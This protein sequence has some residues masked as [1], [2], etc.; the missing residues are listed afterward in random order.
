MLQWRFVRDFNGVLLLI[1]IF[2]EPEFRNLCLQDFLAMCYKYMISQ[3]AY[4]KSI[5]HAAKHIGAVH[6]LLLGRLVDG[7]TAGDKIAD[8]SE[9]HGHIVEPV[10]EIVDALPVAHSALACGTSPITELAL[11]IA[12]K[13]AE[14]LSL[15]LVG[16]YYAPEVADDTD[17][18]VMPTRLADSLRMYCENSCLLVLHARMLVPER[19]RTE[20]AFTLHTMQHPPGQGGSWAKGLRDQRDLVVDANTLKTCDKLLLQSETIQCVYDFED[21]CHNPCQ[22]WF[23]LLLLKNVMT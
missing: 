3:D 12:E 4:C 9:N 20:C 19:R 14:S 17:I 8:E 5:L 2:H 1:P 11:M 22:D 23:N 15:T 21:H 7:H 6:G 18:P 16:A 13:R 10:V